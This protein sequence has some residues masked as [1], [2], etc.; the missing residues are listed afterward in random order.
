MSSQLE[1]SSAQGA[2]VSAENILAWIQQWTEANNLNVPSDLDQTFAEAGF[3]SMHSV[4][5]AFFLEERLNIKIDETVLY[6]YPTFASLAGHLV[7]RVKPA[8][9]NASD[10][11]AVSTDAT[12]GAGNW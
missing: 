3:D 12:G 6:D 11:A 2:N 7:S 1:T 9:T 10:A 5:L 8:E 4:E